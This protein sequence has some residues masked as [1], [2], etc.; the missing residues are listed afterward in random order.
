MEPIH[1]FNGGRGATLCNTCRVIITEGLTDYLY[2]EDCDPIYFKAKQEEDL[3]VDPDYKYMLLRSD[4]LRKK[5]NHVMWIEWN[6]NG[7]FK[8][9][10]DEPAVG[11]S[12]ILDG[13]TVNYTWL[14]TSVKEIL[15]QKENFIN[16]TTKNSHYKLYTYEQI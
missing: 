4:G 13:Q 3:K 14:T 8:N 2:C 6:E 9:T 5:G 12:L 7:T 11:R 15:E 1:K 16:F 10:Y